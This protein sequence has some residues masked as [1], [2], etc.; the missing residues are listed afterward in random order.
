MAVGCGCCG[1]GRWPGRLWNSGILFW[2]SHIVF[3]GDPRGG[4][5][6]PQG[7]RISILQC[8]QHASPLWL[9]SFPPVLPVLPLW[10][11]W[12]FGVRRGDKMAAM[13]GEGGRGG[14][15]ASL[16]WRP[17]S[18]SLMRRVNPFR[19]EKGLLSLGGLNGPH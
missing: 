19:N 12:G 11:R 1:P 14:G 15:W 10:K 7:L 13:C 4:G 18:A 16:P 5:G 2:G 8:I 17:V 9:I 3:W 6:G